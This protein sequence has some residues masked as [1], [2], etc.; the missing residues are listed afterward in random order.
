MQKPYR[1]LVDR[2]ASYAEEGSAF[3]RRRKIRSRPF[4]RVWRSGGAA[5]PVELDSEA[6][7]RLAGA[8]EALIAA[9]PRK[10]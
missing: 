9:S 3:L 7:M 1:F 10:R 5:E 4:A 6:G 8:A 2:V